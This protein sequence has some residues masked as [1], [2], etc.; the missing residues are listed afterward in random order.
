M[1]FVQGQADD[2]CAGPEQPGQERIHKA[3][4]CPKTPDDDYPLPEP[5]VRRGRRPCALQVWLAT[6]SP[7]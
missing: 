6:L 1:G 3:K 5:R 2:A 7:L 4:V